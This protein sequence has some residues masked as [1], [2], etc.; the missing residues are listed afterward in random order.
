MPT[1]T[2]PWAGSRGSGSKRAILTNLH[3]DLDYAALKGVT[4]A[5]VDVAYDGLSLTFTA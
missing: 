5:N 1:W 3:L 4:P 2:R